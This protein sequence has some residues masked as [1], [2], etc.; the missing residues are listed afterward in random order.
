MNILT[1][2]HLHAGI[3]GKP[4]LRGLSLSI[5]KGEIVALMGPNG[6]GK[7]TLAHVLMGDP[8]YIVTEGS[9]Y[10]DGKDLLSLST[11]ERARA[12]LFMAFQYPVELPGIRVSQF[13]FRIAELRQN[14]PAGYTA[15]H[16]ELKEYMELL[17]IDPT[18]LDRSVNEGFS[19]GE[20]K[21]MEILQLL[22]IQPR[23]AIFDETDSGLDVDA[24]R[25]VAQ[26]I[27]YLRG[28]HFS[29]L[30]ITHYRRLLD[31]VPVDRVHILEEGK[32]T[33]TGD[34]TLVEALEREGFGALRVE[35]T[36]T[37]RI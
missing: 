6:N 1:I 13:L 7:S 23:F 3:E 19:G 33:R 29:A 35:T 11:H 17:R 14:P 12:G 4:I 22:V 30:V 8:R 36:K 34:F 20:K 16:R 21:R 37:G 25:L 24:L 18:F 31:L 5:T 10:F 26:G 15:F 9:V 2:E 32:I 27:N 28:P